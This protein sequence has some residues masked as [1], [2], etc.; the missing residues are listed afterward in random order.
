MSISELPKQ[1]SLEEEVKELREKVE[2]LEKKTLSKD[3]IIKIVGHSIQL[4][5]LRSIIRGIIMPFRGF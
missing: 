3:D 4:G 5:S 1:I 2:A